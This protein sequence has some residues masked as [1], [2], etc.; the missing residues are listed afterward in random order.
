MKRCYVLLVV[1]IFKKCN[2]NGKSRRPRNRVGRRTVIAASNQAHFAFPPDFL[3]RS[4]C[5][6]SSKLSSLLPKLA[7]C[8]LVVFRIRMVV[9]SISGTSFKLFLTIFPTC[10][11]VILSISFLFKSLS[12]S[13]FRTF[14]LSTGLCFK[15]GVFFNFGGLILFSA[16]LKPPCCAGGLF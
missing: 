14:I 8:S 7:N 6:M 5:T 10:R 12:F 16:G 15:E 2:A 11:F 4:L 9:V 1:G 13:F 3:W